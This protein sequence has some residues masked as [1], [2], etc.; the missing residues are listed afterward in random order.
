MTERLTEIRRF[1][2][3]DN[4]PWVV[5]ILTESSAINGYV[6]PDG[7]AGCVRDEGKYKNKDD[8]EK[9]EA[10]YLTKCPEK[11]LDVETSAGKQ[12][13]KDCV[14]FNPSTQGNCDEPGYGTKSGNNICD[15]FK[16]IAST[17]NVR[18]R[19]ER[20]EQIRTFDTGATRDTAKG[21]LSYVRALSPIVLQRYVQY[22]DAHR[23]QPDGSLRDFD[24]WKKGIP[25]ET[26][27][28]GLGRHFVAAWLLAQGFL[29]GD[30]HGLV[31]L[32]DTLCAIIFGA[33]GWLHELLKEKNKP[34]R[35][36]P[37]SG[38]Y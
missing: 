27:L 11:E 19:H 17:E 26:Y 25:E 35:T 32:E 4:N 31:T 5:D 16:P 7:T 13:C 18:I 9:A 28:D 29:A 15:R 14:N 34:D 3:D 24:N 12:T 38:G 30:N 23:K 22:L 1:Y 37:V 21:K 36:E 2:L 6:L 10:L 20:K 8:A 33:S